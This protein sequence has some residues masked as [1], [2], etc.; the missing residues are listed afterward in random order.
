MFS[1]TLAEVVQVSGRR[2]IRVSILPSIVF[3]ALALTVAVLSTEDPLAVL[4]GWLSQPGDAKA[5]TAGAFVL[6]V[7]LVSAV[8]DSAQ[9]ILLR[10][11]E[12]YWGPLI[13][14]ILND[15]GYQHH[16]RQLHNAMSEDV[17]YRYPPVTRSHEVM[18]TTLGNVLKSA[19]IYPLM[20]YGI[21]SVLVWPRLFHVL[22]E[23]TLNTLG[24]ARS[25]L[26]TLLNHAFLTGILSLISSG[27]V[28]GTDGPVPL[29]LTCLWGGSLLSW[30][31]Y[32]GAVNRA[33]AYGQHIRSTFDLYRGLLLEAV[34]DETASESTEERDQWKR[35]CLFWHRGVPRDHQSPSNRDQPSTSVP[36]IDSNQ[37]AHL[38]FSQ[39]GLVIIFA[40]G[41]IGSSILLI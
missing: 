33:I 7:L 23:S 31:F 4:R 22:P 15:L 41:V 38:S 20:H 37:E 2:A 27:Y 13:T 29:F 18:P 16:R 24:A 40:V 17:H 21:D 5:L 28:L 10:G 11:A 25:D 32:R 30:I 6:T 1:T 34:G 26:S 3:C 19:E 36:D 39:I 9:M 35:W 14:R 8:M 12:G